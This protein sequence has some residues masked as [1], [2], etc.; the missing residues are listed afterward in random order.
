MLIQTKT[1]LKVNKSE[2]DIP[3][4]HETLNLDK[5]KKRKSKFSF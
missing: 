5:P 4:S 1:T 3:C 2:L